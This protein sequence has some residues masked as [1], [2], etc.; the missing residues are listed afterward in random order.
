MNGASAFSTHVTP[1]KAGIHCPH[2]PGSI[3]SA[4]VKR[5]PAS[6][7]MTVEGRANPQTISYIGPA[8]PPGR[9]PGPT[10][11]KELT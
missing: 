2:R 10:K 1:A 8:R 7:G 5:I 11:P 9:R 6:A 3:P 4:A